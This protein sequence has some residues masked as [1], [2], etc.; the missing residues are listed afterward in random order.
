MKYVCRQ[1]CQVRI[2]DQITLCNKGQIYE[3]DEPNDRFQAIAEEQE[4][5]KVDFLKA[6][7]AELK[8]AK[9]SFTEAK[10]AIKAAYD[11]T[12]TNAKGT[13]RMNVIDQILDA[14]YRAIDSLEIP[15]VK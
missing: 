7:E 3:L 11:V 5:Y 8:E 9:W 6:S 13:S 10:K 15:K 2:K 1:T 12:L 4:N 14:R